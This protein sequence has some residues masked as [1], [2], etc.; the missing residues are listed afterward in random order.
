MSEALEV[1]DFS[2]SSHGSSDDDDDEA[3]LRPHVP[4]TPRSKQ[5]I[6]SPPTPQS[7]PHSIS[8]TSSPPLSPSPNPP[9]SSLA[10]SISELAALPISQIIALIES[11]GAKSYGIDAVSV[12]KRQEGI[13]FMNEL[14]GGNEGEVDEKKAVREI[15]QKLGERLFK[16]LKSLGIKGAVSHPYL[17]YAMALMSVM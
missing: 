2:S 8:H 13:Q 16:V 9:S 6:A 12:E 5:A 17:S 10:A 14:E 15:K 3:E 1:L 7:Q 11:G 4:V